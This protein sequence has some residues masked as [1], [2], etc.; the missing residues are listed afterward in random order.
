MRSGDDFDKRRFPR[1]I[2][3]EQRMDF[4]CVEIEGNALQCADRAEG[5]FDR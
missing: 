5:F 3:T 1:T 4:T 2:L